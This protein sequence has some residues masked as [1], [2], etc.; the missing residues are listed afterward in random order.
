MTDLRQTDEYAQ[1]MELIGWKAKRSAA[2][3]WTYWRKIPVIGLSIMK[4]Q[5]VGVDEVDWEE[6]TELARRNR[7]I[8]GYIEPADESTPEKGWRSKLIS[9]G[10]RAM[11]SGL[12]PTKTRVIDV[13]KPLS[14]M[15]AEMKVKTRYN[16]GRAGRYNLKTQVVNGGELI[17]QPQ[18]F[19]EVEQLLKTHAKEIGYWGYSRNYM[20]A[21]LKAFDRRSFLVRVK[22]EEGTLIAGA[23]F[24]CTSE[25]GYYSFN[26]STKLGRQHHAPT[27][28]IWEGIRELK[29]RNLG[30]L[31]LDGVYDE[32]YPLKRWRGFSRFKAGFGG[33]LW[34]YPPAYVKF[35]PSRK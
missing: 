5:R 31:D 1:F 29:R 17:N 22:S 14:E 26:G 21:Y 3:F 24:L 27:L 19:H 18:L 30:W 35:L 13:M 25:G 20:R 34:Y 4:L 10:Y 16:L 33:K 2:G 15:K 32:R 23:L 6:L 7:V 11:R 28:A 8:V 12:L 9:H